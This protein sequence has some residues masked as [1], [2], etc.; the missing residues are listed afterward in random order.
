MRRLRP[1]PQAGLVSE[2]G[3]AAA[4]DMSL[5]GTPVAYWGAQGTPEADGA[6]VETAQDLLG[7]SPV[8]TA[9]RAVTGAAAGTL[10]SVLAA[11]GAACPVGG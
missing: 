3:L 4:F 10:T 2:L 5:Y 8:M 9:L 6:E 11:T 7:T 1:M